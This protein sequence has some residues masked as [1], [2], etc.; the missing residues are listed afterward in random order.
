MNLII[1]TISNK[2]KKY[3]NYLYEYIISLRNTGYND[4]ILI[5]LYGNFNNE[6]L[7]FLKKYQVLIIYQK[8]TNLINN[9]RIFDIYNLLNILKYEKILVTD[10][11]IWFQDSIYSLFDK[12]NDKFIYTSDIPENNKIIGLTYQNIFINKEEEIQIINKYNNIINNYQTIINCGVLGGK[13]NILKNKFKEYIEFSKKTYNK[14]GLDTIIFNSIFNSNK[15]NIIK[16]KY[17]YLTKQ[18]PKLINGIYYTHE[19]EKI[20]IMHNAGNIIKKNPYRYKLKE[21]NE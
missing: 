8:N 15:D 19:N 5:L 2:D 3:I 4:D 18:K 11:D 9:Q 1:S 12:M 13:K 7:N 16:Y 17:N 20:V 10:I 21:K 14:Y 6:I